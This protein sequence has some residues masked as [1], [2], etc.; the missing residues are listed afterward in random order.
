MKLTIT[1]QDL[2][3]LKQQLQ[4]VRKA[5]LSAHQR[6]DYRSVGKLTCEAAQLN[7]TIQDAE[8]MLMLQAA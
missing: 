6:G 3:K 2:Q 1:E 7:R 8:G 4:S 5:S